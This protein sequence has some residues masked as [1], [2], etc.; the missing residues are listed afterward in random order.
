MKYF[1]II[2]SALILF[3][4]SSTAYAANPFTAKSNKDNITSNV[5][6]KNR[7]FDK[8][9]IWQYKL[10][11]KMS[12]MINEAKTTKSLKPI[13]SLILI[14]FIYGIIH[15]AGPGH[16][17]VI[18]L[19]YIL[20]QRPKFM[21][22]ILFGNLIGLFHGLSGI[23]FVMIIKILLQKNISGNLDKVSNITQLISFSLIL[24]LGFIIFI[25]SIL[26]LIK[27]DKKTDYN[28]TKLV[29]PFVSGLAIGIIPCPGVI[30]IMLF[31]ISMDLTLLGIILGI[32]VSIGMSVTITSV[33]LIGMSGKATLLSLISQKNSRL[34]IEYLIEAIAGFFIAAL[35]FIFLYANFLN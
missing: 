33:V 32:A 4:I 21:H 31:T 24:C 2:F 30:M 17:K 35:G 27:T 14:A 3:S 12:Y 8:I 7:F 29:N 1:I 6:I 10:K 9:V 22:G 13:I 19:S 23:F 25:K 18:A 11:Q 15:A 34:K 16:G 28:K 5:P 20:S 26:K